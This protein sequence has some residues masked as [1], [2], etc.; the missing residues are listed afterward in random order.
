MAIIS[1]TLLLQPAMGISGAQTSFGTFEGNPVTLYT[2]KNKSG[3]T[4]KIMDFGATVVSISTK[5]RKGRFDD[6][7]LG[8]DTFDPYP[9]KSPYFGAIVGRIGNRIAK[10]KFTLDG[11]EYTLAVNNGENHLHGGKQGF[12]KRIWTVLTKPTAEN[13]S[14]TFQYV[15]ADGEEGYPGALTVTVK[16]TV[17][18]QNA[19]KIDYAITTDARTIH[20]ITNH[21]YF[22]LG[23]KSAK[24]ILGH[25]LQIKATQ[26][27]PVDKGLIP[28]GKLR[29][30]KGTP[31]DFRTPKGI[32]TRIGA[33]DEQL[34]FGGGYDHNF[35]LDGKAGSLRRAINVFEPR[36]G[37]TME[38]WTTEPGVQLYTGNFLDGTL[39]GHGGK[40]YLHRGAFCLETQHYPDSINQKNF[41]SVVLNPGQTYKSTTIY[42]FGAR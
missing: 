35:V 33:K 3:M 29:A 37:R 28:T 11:K 23:G 31:F 27:T 20:N 34:K 12:D 39:V 8:F 41:P 22:N 38:V 1:A 42:K 18:P 4:A 40:K 17:T 9:T 32:G 30:V 10:G 13:P 19:L 5:D 7:A 21:T 16:Y 25:R 15:S 36:S 24:D 6:V 2:L 26:M 14:I